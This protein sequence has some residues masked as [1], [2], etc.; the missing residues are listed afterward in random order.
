MTTLKD[1]LERLDLSRY[2]DALV[3]EGF[4]T[5][6]TLMDITESDLE[7]LGVKLGHRRKL[8]RAILNASKDRTPL[9]LLLHSALRD[10]SVVN[11]EARKKRDS[12]NPQL[13]QQR[14]QDSTTQETSTTSA[15]NG[16]PTRSKRKYRR[17]PKA[18][19]H[20]P[21]RPPSA[22]VI[23][24]NQV[25]D[26][27][28]GKDLSFTEIAKLVGERWQEL[29][30]HEKEPCEREAQA[31]K[32]TYYSELRTYKKTPQY[33]AY[34][35]YLIDFR[36]K[37]SESNA[38]GDA[39]KPKTRLSSG[40]SRS[41]DDSHMDGDEGVDGLDGVDAIDGD[42]VQPSPTHSS[43][44]TQP[45][46]QF[47]PPRPTS[48]GDTASSYS[49]WRS[50][51]QADSSTA[52]PH[53]NPSISTFTTYTTSQDDD[54]STSPTSSRPP[55]SSAHTS[56]PQQHQIHQQRPATK[57]PLLPQ[58]QPSANTLPPLSHL[59]AHAPRKTS[60]TPLMNWPLHTTLPPIVPN[61]PNNHHNSTP[62]SM[63]SSPT[64]RHVTNPPVVMRPI[65]NGDAG[66]ERNKASLSTLLRASEHVDA[67]D[68]VDAR[69]GSGRRV[70]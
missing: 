23:F 4:D 19:E 8:Q 30:A 29:Q 14:S 60:A 47:P 53:R 67:R 13:Q 66:A 64:L 21:E 38:Q 12:Q 65:Q 7:A 33:K 51:Q 3:E 68:A 59:D 37:H 50:T 22:Y 57:S 31:L 44:N 48:S 6:E 16:Q 58:Q 62:S 70:S 2:H 45:F 25:R 56:A 20:A 69:R 55:L 24:S 34:Q 41:Y 52:M 61:G 5:W 40:Q 32:D 54:G 11:D 42:Q 43:P 15:S 10:D 49:T 1:F 9:P 63:Y 18:D 27:L 36:A 26:E 28:K 46:R 17:H 35:E 39:K